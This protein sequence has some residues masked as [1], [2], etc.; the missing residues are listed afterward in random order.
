MGES[1]KAKW[2]EISQNLKR[3]PPPTKN[4]NRQNDYKINKRNHEFAKPSITIPPITKMRDKCAESSGIF[5]QKCAKNGDDRSRD[6]ATTGV[7]TE[8][9]ETQE[10][11]AA[12]RQLLSRPAPN[13]N[14]F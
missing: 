14:D 2:G 8:W 11:R 13:F 6:R 10:P 12:N 1:R 9:D 7:K 5:G 3:T 4:Q